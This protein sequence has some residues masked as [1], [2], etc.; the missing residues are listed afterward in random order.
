MAEI[1]LFHHAQGLTAGC[2]AFA[3]ELRAAG[4]TVHAPDLYDGNTFTE[5]TEGVAYAKQVGFG[6]VLERGLHA[7]E[8]M[9]NELVYAGFSLG[10]MPAQQLAQTRPG[11]K[12]ALL[13]YSAIPLSEFGGTWPPGVPMQIHMMEQDEWVLEGD[14]DVAREFAE[15]IAGAELFLYPGDRH[16]FADNSLS[17]Y[18]EKAATLLKQR[19]LSFLDKVE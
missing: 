3:D 14:L 11:A 10:V 16:L 2:L 1:L 9:P 15:T 13:F 6:T 19:V 4:H 12:G 18:D 7:A 17:D 5:I 8:D